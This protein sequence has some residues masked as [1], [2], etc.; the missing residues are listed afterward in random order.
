MEFITHHKCASA[1]LADILH[2]YFAL[3]H[4]KQVFHTAR[5]N[6]Y[7]SN[8]DDFVYVLFANGEWQFLHSKIRRAVHIIRNP[9]ALIVSAYFSHLK[10]HP[11]DGWPQLSEQRGRLLGTE[12]EKE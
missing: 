4:Q 1:W 7:P 11:E 6:D 5:G 9:L 3:R 2:E 10:S 12:V 8:R